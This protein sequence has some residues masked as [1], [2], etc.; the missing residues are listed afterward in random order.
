MVSDSYFILICVKQKNNFWTEKT[1]EA[2]IKWVAGKGSNNDLY[3][4]HI[5]HPLIFYSR[6]II[7]LY[8]W[9]TDCY[10]PDKE[11]LCIELATVAAV[12]LLNKFDAS[13]SERATNFL[14]TVLRDYIRSKYMYA[15]RAKRTGKHVYI[16]DMTNNNVENPDSP[17]DYILYEMDGINHTNIDK[18]ITADIIQWF[19]DNGYKHFRGASLKCMYLILDI[20]EHPEKHPT[21]SVTKHYVSYTNYI[22]KKI[23]ISKQ[24][25]FQILQR[26]HKA[27][28]PFLNNY[29]K[30][31]SNEKRNKNDLVKASGRS[32]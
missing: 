17:L 21:K 10:C 12:T 14:H 25:I 2:V 3:L 16:D 31:I 20:I 9:N 1:E 19:K 30:V 28:Q 5:H 23:G 32:L 11:E 26:M 22:I 27:I 7:G 29:D 24:R 6:Y 13:R 8:A 18:E 15:S 4:D